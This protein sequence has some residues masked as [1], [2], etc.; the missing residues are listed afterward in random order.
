MLHSHVCIRIFYLLYSVC[1]SSILS[2]NFATTSACPFSKMV[3]IADSLAMRLSCFQLMTLSTCWPRPLA[4]LK[5]FPINV[6]M[7]S[8]SSGKSF[9]SPFGSPSAK[10][11]YSNGHLIHSLAYLLLQ[12]NHYLP[13]ANSSIITW[14]TVSVCGGDSLTR[15]QSCFL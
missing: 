2:A 9:E 10:E 1:G 3:D 5:T 6:R 7:N 12:L 15:S 8:N 11:C 4:N 13:G 14:F